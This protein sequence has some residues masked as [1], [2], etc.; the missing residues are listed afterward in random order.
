[1]SRI[2]QNTKMRDRKSKAWSESP[3]FFRLAK[4]I[5]EAA[6]GSVKNIRG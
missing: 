4:N 6:P 3:L 1:M 2:F 5:Q